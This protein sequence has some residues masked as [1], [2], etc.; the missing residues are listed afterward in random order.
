MIE[1]RWRMTQDETKRVIKECPKCGSKNL[2]PIGGWNSSNGY[3]KCY[4]CG[5]GPFWWLKRRDS[6]GSRQ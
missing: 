5:H 2:D 1:E 6:E 4:D 3:I